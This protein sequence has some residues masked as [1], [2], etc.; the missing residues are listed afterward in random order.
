[1]VA[2]SLAGFTVL[3]LAAALVLLPGNAGVMSAS[4]IGAYGFATAGCLVYAWIGALLTSRV[5][6]RTEADHLECADTY[7]PKRQTAADGSALAEPGC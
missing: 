2:W 6:T 3:V 5:P 1:V 7:H 4:R